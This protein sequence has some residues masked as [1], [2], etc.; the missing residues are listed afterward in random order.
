MKLAWML[1]LAACG[2]RAAQ[3]APVQRPQPIPQAEPEIGGMFTG[4]AEL[5]PDA[6]VRELAAAPDP[7][8]PPSDKQP[9]VDELVRNY[10]RFA[11][12]AAKDPTLTSTISN[13][14]LI[15]GHG[16]ISAVRT[17]G[18]GNAA[19]HACMDEAIHALVFGGRPDGK[20]MAITWNWTLKR[21]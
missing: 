8:Q 4:G 15:D 1:G 19:V 10:D 21:Y 7:P 6:T 9:I 3:P 14:F 11:A 13:H 18:D 2:G 20:A 12:C 16:A 5:V 17:D